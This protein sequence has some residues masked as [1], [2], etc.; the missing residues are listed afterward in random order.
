MELVWTR[1]VLQTKIRPSSLW[2]SPWPCCFPEPPLG[3]FR[4]CLGG[5]WTIKCYTYNVMGIAMVITL[6]FRIYMDYTWIYILWISILYV[7]IYNY[8]Y[9]MHVCINYTFITGN[10]PSK[11]HMVLLFLLF[12]W[13]AM[14]AKQLVPMLFHSAHIHFTK[15]G[16]KNG[17]KSYQKQEALHEPGLLRI[18]FRNAPGI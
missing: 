10:A 17:S 11:Y 8:I 15:M 4:G 14:S 9:N 13:E 2:E 12:C 7:Y 18:N 3:P 16:P 1:F 5:D 6:K